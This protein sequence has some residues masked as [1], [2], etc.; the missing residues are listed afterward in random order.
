MTVV[1]RFLYGVVRGVAWR[2]GCTE[3]YHG[4]TRVEPTIDETRR[5]G[6]DDVDD[7]RSSARCDGWR[8]TRDGRASR[9]MYRIP[10]VVRIRDAC[11]LHSI[12][13]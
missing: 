2:R 10:E 1:R 12:P 3:R 8:A 5:P 7:S 6:V 13:A 4:E 11:S 9:R